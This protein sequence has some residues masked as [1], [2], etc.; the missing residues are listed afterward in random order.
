MRIITAPFESGYSQAW[1]SF[2]PDGKWVLLS[3]WETKANGSVQHQLAIAPTDGSAPARRIGPVVDDEN[4][5]K[6]WAPDGSRILLCT[7]ESKELYTVD[8][9]TG[10]FEK[11]P[12]QV[13]APG[14]QRLAR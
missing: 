10:T 13:D 8:P 1:P 11:L 14:W 2:S 6:S 7:C 12:W 9:I 4:Q 5:V 3:S